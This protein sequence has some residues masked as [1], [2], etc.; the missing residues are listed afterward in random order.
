M[1]PEGKIQ[2]A[3][4][5]YATAKGCVARKYKNEGRRSAPDY[6]FFYGGMVLMIEFKAS[7]KK[8]TKAQEREA[9][10]YRNVGILVFTID[11]ID[12]GKKL[13]GKFIDGLLFI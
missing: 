5:K 12:D 10:I 2:K 1:T 6:I 4:V 3:V 7:G 9:G 11:N 13:I 8:A